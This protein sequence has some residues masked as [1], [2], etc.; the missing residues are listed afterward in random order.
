MA[1]ACGALS[2]TVRHMWLA[3]FVA[4]LFA[5][6]LAACNVIPH[7][8]VIGAHAITGAVKDAVTGAPI[9]GVTVCARYSKIGLRYYVRG[10]QVTGGS[11]KFRIDKNPEKVSLL[12]GREGLAPSLTFTHPSYA[13]AGY[14]FQTFDRDLEL[15]ILLERRSAGMVPS[16][17]ITCSESAIAP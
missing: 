15:N 4:V 8:G 11:G 17:H 12:D 1:P 13:E 7:R 16:P 9:A 14:I 3:R 6:M 10:F 5:L 2:C